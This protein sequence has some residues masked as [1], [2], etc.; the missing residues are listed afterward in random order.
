MR[1]RKKTIGP[2]NG[3]RGDLSREQAIII[4]GKDIVENVERRPPEFTYRTLENNEKWIE[5]SARVFFSGCYVAVYYYQFEDNLDDVDYDHSK[6]NWIIH[7][8]EVDA[9]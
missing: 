2:F 1:S 3:R 8:Y 7:G 4:A 6:C 5:F 9:R